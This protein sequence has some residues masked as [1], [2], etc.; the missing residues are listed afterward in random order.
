MLSIIEPQKSYKETK[1][2]LES[3]STLLKKRGLIKSSR[4]LALKLCSTRC[5]DKLVNLP[6]D[7][8]LKILNMTEAAGD[9]IQEVSIS[10]V[11]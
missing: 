4:F 8:D 6:L 10:E 5:A 7:T 9:E 11:R 2:L 3:V 1:T